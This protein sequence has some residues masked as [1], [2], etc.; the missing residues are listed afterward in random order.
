MNT[1]TETLRKHII[2]PGICD[3]TQDT[4]C[5]KQPVLSLGL[6]LMS[7]EKEKANYQSGG[8]GD[9][10]KKCSNNMTSSKSK[11]CLDGTT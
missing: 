8:W 3:K 11:T 1:F 10:R 5:G 7:T 6:P 4:G 2:L 9:V